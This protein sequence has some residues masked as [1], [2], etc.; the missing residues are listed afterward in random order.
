VNLKLRLIHFLDFLDDRV[1]DHRFPWLCDRLAMCSWWGDH[2]CG[3]AGCVPAVE[4][5]DDS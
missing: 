1:L 4:A 2:D 3:K 5:A